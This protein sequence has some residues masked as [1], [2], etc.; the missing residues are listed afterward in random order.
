MNVPTPES[1]STRTHRGGIPA[2]V[3]FGA[4]VVVQYLIVSYAVDAQDLLRPARLDAWLRQVG[5]LAP[6]AFLFVAAVFVLGGRAVRL[7]LGVLASY[8]AERKW[9]LVLGIAHAGLFLGVVLLALRIKSF[10]SVEPLVARLWLA[11]WFAAV[12]ACVVTLMLSLFSPRTLLGALRGLR[13]ELSLG[14]FVS[15]VAWIAGLLAQQVWKPLAW[16]TLECVHA[17]LTLMV[18]DPLASIE[19]A[20]VGTSRFYV[21]IAPAC[22][23]IEGIGLML[24]FMAAFLYVQRR[25]LFWPRSLVLLPLAAVLVWLLNVV[26]V[27]G[28]ILVG[29]WWSPEVALGGFHSKA[30]WVFFALSALGTVL[31]VQRSAMFCLQAARREAATEPRAVEASNPPLVFHNTPSHHAQVTA[32]YLVPLL[33]VL[34]I[35]LVTGLAT[36]GFDYFYPIGVVAAACMLFKFRRHYLP[37]TWGSLWLPVTV[38][39]VVAVVWIV[40]FRGQDT[41][42]PIAGGLA[43]LPFPLAQL[44][45]SVRIVG[46]VITVPIVE[47]LAFRGFLLRRF[48]GH[49]FDAVPYQHFS[50]LGL[51]V[52]S[53]VFGVLHSQW[54]LGILAGLAFGL[55]TVRTGRL[56]DAVVAHATANAGIVVHVLISRQWALLG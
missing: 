55:L 37:V 46:S 8:R 19:L 15:V 33:S 10:D 7:R 52:S 32:A 9:S 18:P 50:W 6:L 23:G 3:L 48:V 4:L 53:A 39:A 47:E 2:W 41:S 34:A 51:L 44:W 27:T 24:T 40:G 36:S 28:L 49:N 1:R 11:I 22:S 56:S 30:G 43:R 17:I 54:E 21:E 26:R 14:L 5:Q 45:L 25:E 20:L 29:T 16:M 31:Y 12:L 35:K 42:S 13:R 38:G